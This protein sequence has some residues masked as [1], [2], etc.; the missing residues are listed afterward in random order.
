M[1]KL[2]T[3]APVMSAADSCD[4]WSGLF[5]TVVVWAGSA[6]GAAGG[7]SEYQ[8]FE[9][10]SGI[11]VAQSKMQIPLADKDFIRHERRLLSML[12]P[13]LLG[14]KML[15][16]SMVR[17]ASAWRSDAGTTKSMVKSPSALNTAE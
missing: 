14:M 11:C 2:F 17:F 12:A 10:A 7:E 9:R 1:K 3:S 6:C 4:A 8:I 5:A 15:L 16:H 13:M